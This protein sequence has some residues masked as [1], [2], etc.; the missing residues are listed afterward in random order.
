ML[1]QGGGSAQAWLYGEG[2]VSRPRRLLSLDDADLS[3]HNLSSHLA[4]SFLQTLPVEMT[5]DT[6]L[7]DAAYALAARWDAA[8]HASK[9]DFSPADLKDFN[10][11]QKGACR[12]IVCALK[13]THA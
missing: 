4:C 5:Y 13:R 11:M 7:A 12:S 1:T 2:L 3:M 6:S 10:T 9:L 8:R